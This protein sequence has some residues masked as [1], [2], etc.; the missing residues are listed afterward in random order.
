MWLSSIET[1]FRFM[2]CPKEHKLQCVVFMLTGNVEIWWRLAEKMIDTSGKLA[3]WEQFKERFYE[4]YF[5]ANTR[6][7]KQVEFLNLK[8][9]VMLVKEYEQEFDKLSHFAA[10]LVATETAR[11]ERFIQGLRSELRGMVHALDLNT[12]ATALR[13]VVRIDADSQ[14]GEEYNKLSEIR[15][16]AGQK[17]KADQKTSEFQQKK[18]VAIKEEKPICNSYGKRH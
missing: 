9:G 10:E 11:T 6:Y 1:I 17:R 14:E 3:T 7:N 8:Q 2:K 5:S 16:S 13:A 15:A 12:Y 18:P 4:K